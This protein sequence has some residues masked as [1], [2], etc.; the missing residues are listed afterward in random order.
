MAI[1]AGHGPETAFWEIR[2]CFWASGQLTGRVKAGALRSPAGAAEAGARSR[3]GLSVIRPEQRGPSGKTLRL[4]GFPLLI[5]Q[6][7]P[8]HFRL[9]DPSPESQ[10]WL[11]RTA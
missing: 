2:V 9:G 6:N 8:D 1:A 5:R 11:P 10:P 3:S 4:V 7:G